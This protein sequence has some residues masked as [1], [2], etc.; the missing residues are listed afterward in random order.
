MGSL[1]AVLMLV[2]LLVDGEREGYWSGKSL[3][4]I[5]GSRAERRRSASWEWCFRTRAWIVVM[6][7]SWR[8]E[9]VRD[10]RVGGGLFMLRVSYY[11]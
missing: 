1:R 6:R 7:M 8:M 4:I 9:R 10:C 3:G 11:M 2:T 5:G